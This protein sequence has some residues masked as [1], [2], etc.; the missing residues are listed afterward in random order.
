MKIEYLESDYFKEETS[1][2]DIC[3][4]FRVPNKHLK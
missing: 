1:L 2:E 4:P 3:S